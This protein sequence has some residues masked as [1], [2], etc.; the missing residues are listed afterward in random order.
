VGLTGNESPAEVN[1]N[2]NIMTWLES[3][4]G[5]AAQACGLITEEQEAASLSP[6]IPKIAMVSSST[7]NEDA[8]F[9]ATMISMGKTHEAFALTGAIAVASAAKMEDTVVHS[10]ARSSND[11]DV[12]F[13]HPSGLM[14]LKVE[15]SDNGSGNPKILWVSTVR[16]A[17]KLMQG[18]V[19]VPEKIPR[20]EKE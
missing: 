4:R 6:A 9:K 3:V 18:F 8:Q 12:T 20:K 17:R 19:R 10:V 14:T 5:W 2:K 1:D 16:T 7:D 11:S 15:V 13:Q